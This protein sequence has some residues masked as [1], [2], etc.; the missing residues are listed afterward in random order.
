MEVEG[1]RYS[2]L[3]VE[4][5][6]LTPSTA[7]DRARELIERKEGGYLVFCTVSTV[8][9]SGD[10]PELLT[11]L[12]QA[13]VVA[14][15]GM[16]LV[17]LG[18]RAGFSTERVY[19][20]DFLLHLLERT[21]GAYRHFLYG[22]APGVAEK[23]AAEL[24]RRFPLVKIVGTESPPFGAA[25]HDRTA[26]NLDKV[27]NASPDLVWVGLG[28]PRQ[29]KWMRLH[30]Q[31]LGGAVAAGVGAAFDFLSGE[32]KEAPSWMK[33]SGLQWMHRLLSEPQRLWRRYLIGNSRFIARI[34]HE[35][36]GERQRQ[37][38]GG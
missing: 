27:I 12:R 11:S 7:V 5:D 33:R 22:G 28:H 8:V 14:P 34:L 20:P 21:G 18:R 29:E 32:K 38:K 31:A 9:T 16:P 3:G 24:R 19:G 36:A 10:D 15:D 30:H 37:R 2:V 26:W 25:L 6:D 23:L 1:S 4:I 35:K 17:W 13:S